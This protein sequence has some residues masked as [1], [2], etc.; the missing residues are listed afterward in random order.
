MK[1]SDNKK[2]IHHCYSN[3]PTLDDGGMATY[4]RS[5]LNERSPNVSPTVLSSLKNFDQSQCLLLHVHGRPP[6]QELTGECPV[7]Y[8]HHNHSSYC[9]SGTKYLATSKSQCDR[10]MSILACTY[11]HVVDRCGSLRPQNILRNLRGSF[12]ELELLKQLKILVIAN[13]DYIRTQMIANGFPSEYVMTL[14]LGIPSPQTPS[15]PLTHEIFQRRRILFVGRLIPEKGVEWLLEALA[16]MS[17]PVYLDIAGEGW[18]KPRLEKRV[19]QLGLQKWVTW[20]GWCSR[21]K[22]D[23]LFSQCFT[24]VFP[25]VWPEPA[26]LVTL[27]AYAHHRPIIA[28]AIGGIPEYISNG[29][30]GQLVQSNNVSDLVEKITDFSL[31][32]DKSRTMGEMGYQQLQ[33][34][35]LMESHVHQLQKIY[36]KAVFLFHNQ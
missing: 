5:L 8:S 1:M 21:E 25:S 35:F 4:V 10:N 13:S 26:G 17:S 11:G 9:P 36:E 7:V 14:K 24:V 34:E 2:L 31:N 22:L 18:A 20:H 6:L 12:H 32:F 29:K 28:S 30:T 15:Q 33:Q 16:Q 23:H 3:F 19:R 27:E